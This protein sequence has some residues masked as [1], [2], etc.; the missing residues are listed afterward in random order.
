MKETHKK[1]FL[2]WITIVALTL[3]A[4]RSNA[5]NYVV[6]A[7]DAANDSLQ[8][9]FDLSSFYFGGIGAHVPGQF[10]PAYYT[11]AVVNYTAVLNGVTTSATINSGRIYIGDALNGA[12]RDEILIYQTSATPDILL[13]FNYSTFTGSTPL[14]AINTLQNKF[15]SATTAVIDFPGGFRANMT[16]LTVTTV[17]E[18]SA[19]ALASAGAF[20]L[21]MLRV[22]N[23]RVSSKT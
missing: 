18:P 13:Y 1:Y 10:E 11:N 12:Y 21:L 19:L 5:Q 22:G 16:S 6:T 14:T 20:G 2:S 4:A 15:G 23:A 7:Y 8:F 17:P 9:S 3:V